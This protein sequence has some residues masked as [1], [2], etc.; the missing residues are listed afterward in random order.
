MKMLERIIRGVVASPGIS[1]G[2]AV[3]AFDPLFISFNDKR[4]ADQVPEEIVRLL[5]LL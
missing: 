1:I 4:R 5:L 3:R 2:Q